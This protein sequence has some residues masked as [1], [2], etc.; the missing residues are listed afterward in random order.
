MSLDSHSLEGT[1]LL[2]PKTSVLHIFHCGK[3]NLTVLCYY[4]S[5]NCFDKWFRNWIL[6]GIYICQLYSNC[7]ILLYYIVL[8]I[9]L[10]EKYNGILR[11]ALLAIWRRYIHAATAVLNINDCHLYSLFSHTYAIQI[12]R[13]SAVRRISHWKS[14]SWNILYI[15]LSSPSLKT[16]TS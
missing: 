16:L 3:R 6:Y 2:F 4:Y 14:L 8:Y 13:T 1:A 12:R 10:D 11:T 15:K 5:H 7:I 9:Y